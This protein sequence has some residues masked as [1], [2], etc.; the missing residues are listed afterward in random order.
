MNVPCDGKVNVAIIMHRE[1]SLRG[2]GLFSFTG[3]LQH[4]ES[5]GITCPYFVLVFCRHF[6][7]SL[8]CLHVGTVLVFDT[9]TDIGYDIF[10]KINIYMH[11]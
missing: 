2:F 3:F 4:V 6:T 11:A 9:G 1:I 5:G 10:R 8:C 7:F